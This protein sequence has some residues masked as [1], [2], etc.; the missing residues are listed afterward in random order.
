MIKKLENQC[1]NSNIL[2][3]ENKSKCETHRT[4]KHK[5]K[6]IIP[7]LLLLKG[8]TKVLQTWFSNSTCIFKLHLAPSDDGAEFSLVLDQPI[9]G[10]GK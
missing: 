1:L 9:R 4:N 7:N 5:S 8:F 10:K 2:T 3:F 6:S